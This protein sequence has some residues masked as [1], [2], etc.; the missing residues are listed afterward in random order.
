MQVLRYVV[1]VFVVLAGL[2]GCK[3]TAPVSLTTTADEFMPLAM[4]ARRLEIVDNWQMPVEPPYVGHRS[5]TLPSNLLATWASQILQP[6]GGSGELVF[7]ISR[8]SVTRV[9]L[10]LEA[11]IQTLLTDQQ[12]SKI[13]AAGSSIGSHE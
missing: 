6:A 13:E 2:N 12:E 5:Q 3:T 10:P 7:D 9:A 1:I 11:G 8:A 4:N